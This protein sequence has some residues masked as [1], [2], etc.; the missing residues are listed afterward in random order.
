M[1]IKAEELV[2]HYIKNSIQI[3][4]VYHHKIEPGMSGLEQSAPFPG[5]IFPISGQAQYH[6]NG[7]S[8]IV[9]SG[10]VI[11]GGANMRLDKR[12]VGNDK[13]EYIS[14]L[15]DIN[16]ADTKNVYLQNMHF[17]LNIGQS[18]RLIEIL[19]RMW[20]A[21]N[22]G[23]T[24]STF[25]A[26]MLFRCALEEV[27]V[28]GSNKGEDAARGLFDSVS[29]YIR[30]NYMDSL[31]VRGLAEQNNVN[32]NRL[33][34]V[35]NKYAGMGPGDYLI[36]YR[37]NRAKGLLISCNASIARVSESVGYSD[38]LYFSRIFKNRYGVSPS[39]FRKEFRNNPYK[40]QDTCIQI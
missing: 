22:K 40:F 3:K 21:F 29:A 20:R 27:F 23:S 33:F 32:Q 10:K 19:W 26:E 30:D 16:S 8:Y 35:F 17:E 9:G 39:G 2:E 24:I 34:Y 13:W 14:V 6:F 1:K 4:G 37:L 18:P 36:E 15:Y 5:F 38:P 25:Q 11:H 12:V 28:C 7:T 31:T